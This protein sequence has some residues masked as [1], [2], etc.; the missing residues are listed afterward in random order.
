[1]TV[2][3]EQMLRSYVDL[4][5][6]HHNATTTVTALI[7]QRIVKQLPQG[8]NMFLINISGLVTSMS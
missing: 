2:P 6:S 5:I 3:L 7:P 4:L 1:M 8:N